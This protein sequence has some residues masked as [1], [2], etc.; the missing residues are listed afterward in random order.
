MCHLSDTKP[1]GLLGQPQQLHTRWQY[2]TIFYSFV[3]VLIAAYTSHHAPSFSTFAFSS[4]YFP[5][6]YFCDSSYAVSYFQ[7]ST[8]PHV[9]H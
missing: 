2:G 7:P 3:A 5:S 6:L 8:D 4:M 1:M 9:V